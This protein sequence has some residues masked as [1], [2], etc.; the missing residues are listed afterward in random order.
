FAAACLRFLFSGVIMAGVALVAD[1]GKGR[2][3]LRQVA[4]YALIGVL[5][6]GIGN[7]LVMWAEKRIPSG[8]AALIVAA[9]PLYL[10]FF[11]GLRRGGQPW[12]GRVW[13]GVLL[14]LA[15]VALVA[16]PAADMQ[17][18]HWAAVIGLQVATL[19]WTFGS[20]YS[21]SLPRKL[22]LAT[23]AAIEMVA[24]ALVLAVESW[25]AG[26]RLALFAQASVSTWLALLYLG[27]FGSLVGFTAYAYCLN[28]LPAST[29]GTYAYVNPVVAV[30]LGALFL[31]EPLSPGM[32]GG[33]ALILAAVVLTTL[34]T[35]AR[36]SRT[37]YMEVD[38]RS[39]PLD[40]ARCVRFPESGESTT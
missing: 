25:V 11:D 14:G 30:A 29:V 24:A 3:T 9:V 37:R 33:G 35:R 34:N 31:K 40:A 2:P 12:T 21:Q 19:A 18:G 1:R 23:A 38:S 16:R 27:V 32:L 39:T 20:L 6:L 17:P 8:I 36:R 15:G 13:A 4:D 26:E 22:P 5:L 28:E 10:T 7:A